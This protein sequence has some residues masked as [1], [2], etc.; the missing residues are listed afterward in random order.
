MSVALQLAA[1]LN[2]QAASPVSGSDGDLSLDGAAMALHGAANACG[3]GGHVVM[4]GVIDLLD[5]G[6]V[7]GAA[8][9]IPGAA[10]ACECFESQGYMQEALE[11]THL[12]VML[13]HR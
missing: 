3:C 5:G 10:G 4:V 1:L 13:G 6:H 7:A 9:G 2:E 11:A 12:L 8:V